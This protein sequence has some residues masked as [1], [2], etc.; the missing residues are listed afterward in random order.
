MFE[1]KKKNETIFF[2]K[3][4]D[5]CN[6]LKNSKDYLFIERSVMNLGCLPGILS[7]SFKGVD[8]MEVVKKISDG[9]CSSVCLACH[10][11]C[12][13]ISAVHSAIGLYE[14]LEFGTFRISV[15]NELTKEMAICAANLISD[16]VLASIS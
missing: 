9:V 7:I 15:G 6:T 12:K 3:N 16:E 13:K 10:F 11:A 5:L 8:E 1:K 4:E 14:S 2:R